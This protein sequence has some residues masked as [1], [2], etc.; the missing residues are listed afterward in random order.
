M[1]PEAL[2]RSASALKATD[3]L[4]N[5]SHMTSSNGRV[6]HNGNTEANSSQEL[7]YDELF[8]EER[9]KKDALKLLRKMKRKSPLRTPPRTPKA[10]I[11]K[12]RLGFRSEFFESDGSESESGP[13]VEQQNG[14]SNGGN[15]KR[16]LDDSDEE[17]SSSSS[18]SGEDVSVMEHSSGGV[19]DS[20]GG[21]EDSQR[22]EL[23]RSDSEVSEDEGKLTIPE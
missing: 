11:K 16:F 3:S 5:S 7:D 20:S 2:R 22:K 10:N 12:P 6:T 19:E 15:N 9:T 23:G 14:S 13:E 18:E 1:P 4:L 17:E 8:E 21:V